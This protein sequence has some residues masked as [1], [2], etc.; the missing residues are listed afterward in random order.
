MFEKDAVLQ[1]L[2]IGNYNY[3]W[4]ARGLSIQKF[5]R[6]KFLL[7]LVNSSTVLCR[8]CVVGTAYGRG[9]VKS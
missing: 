5:I 6:V 2:T 1:P 3:I 4:N 7:A 8:G 9:P